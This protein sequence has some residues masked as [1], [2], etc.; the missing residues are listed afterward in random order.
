MLHNSFSSPNIIRMIHLGMMR[1]MGHVPP[2]IVKRNE[3]KGYLNHSLEI[4]LNP[5]CTES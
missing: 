5:G 1:C 4:Y 2:M 3:H